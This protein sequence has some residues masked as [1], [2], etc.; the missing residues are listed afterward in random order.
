[1]RRAA[2]IVALV[3]AAA[4]ADTIVLRDGTILE[5][6]VERTV[7]PQSVLVWEKDDGTL[8]QPAEWDDQ[9]RGYRLLADRTT[10]AQC[11]TAL[12][13]ANE[14]K[15][16]RAL[17]ILLDRAEQAGL[18]PKKAESWSRKLTGLVKMKRERLEEFAVPADHALPDL[19]LDRANKTKD[20]NRALRL[21]RA[22]LDHAPR[23]P[24]A[25]ERLERE[26]P[27][28]PYPARHGRNCR[29][30]G[31][32]SNSPSLP[33]RLNQRDRLL[34]HFV[35][36]RERR[37]ARNSRWLPGILPDGRICLGRRSDASRPAFYGGPGPGTY[38]DGRAGQSRSKSC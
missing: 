17:R 4:G 16:S 3:C 37:C 19:L 20:K 28:E 25:L 26:A 32:P 9:L 30:A 15:D 34:P 13:R 10:L 2:A 12:P 8:K 31:R 35:A 7:R 21:L 24:E 1:M 27:A 29:R 33:L 5:G 11:R 38:A 18:D 14:V 23:H 6:T 36:P 22:A